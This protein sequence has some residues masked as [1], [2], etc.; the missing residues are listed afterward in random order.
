MEN[1]IQDAEIIEQEDLSYFYIVCERHDWGD[2]FS[3]Y[4]SISDAEKSFNKSSNKRIVIKVKNPLNST[5]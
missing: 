4:I 2:S 3:S 1:K 5:L